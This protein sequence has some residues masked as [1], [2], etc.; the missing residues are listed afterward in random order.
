M[1]YHMFRFYLVLYIR[2]LSDK[3]FNPY[4][5]YKEIKEHQE[6]LQL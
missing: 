5:D 3:K 2:R 1:Y 6:K 4:K